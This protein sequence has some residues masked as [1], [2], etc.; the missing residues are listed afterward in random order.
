MNPTRLCLTV[1]SMEIRIK[2]P[3]E[4]AADLLRALDN[5]GI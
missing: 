1:I 3:P 4:Y 2:N 5:L